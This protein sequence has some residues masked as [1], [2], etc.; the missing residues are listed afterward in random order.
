MFWPC[1]AACRVLVPWP[2]I[3][4][5]PPAS[6]AQ[7]LNHWTAREVPSP[8]FLTASPSVTHSCQAASPGSCEQS[9]SARCWQAIIKLKQNLQWQQRAETRGTSMMGVW[10]EPKLARSQFAVKKGTI[11]E[12]GNIMMAKRMS[13][14][15]ARSG[16]EL[17]LH[18]YQFC[19]FC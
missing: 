7:S 1:H 5:G 9:L 18:Y 2:G 16:F 4:P 10:C 15:S 14:T 19:D 12:G 13:F 17:W 3:E 6:G 11:Q 8:F